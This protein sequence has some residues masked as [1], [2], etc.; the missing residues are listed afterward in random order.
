MD[1]QRALP[2]IV[3]QLIQRCRKCG[4]GWIASFGDQFISGRNKIIVMLETIFQ[5]IENPVIVIL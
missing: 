1:L 2:G 4:K 5:A 3:R